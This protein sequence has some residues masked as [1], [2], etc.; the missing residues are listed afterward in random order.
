[1]KDQGKVYWPM[2]ISNDSYGQKPFQI[3]CNA[4]QKFYNYS[5]FRLQV[6]EDGETGRTRQF[7]KNS[8]TIMD[9]GSL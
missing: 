5:G 3:H 4:L 8:T 2:K 7:I 6:I 9:I 1:M